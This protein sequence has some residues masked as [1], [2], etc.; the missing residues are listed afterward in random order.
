[1]N[2]FQNLFLGSLLITG[3]IITSSIASAYENN[4]SKV[5]T[6]FH[7]DL[8]SSMKTAKNISLKKRYK[9]IAPQIKKSFHFHLMT[10]VSAGSFWRKA[11]NEQ[12]E[13]LISAFTH[14]TISNYVSRFDRYTGQLFLTKS[15][16]P[17]PQKT[18]LVKTQII[19]SKSKL[20]DITYVTKQIKD[21]WGIIDVL[22]GSGISELA[23]KRSEYQQIL[24]NNG[25]DGLIATLN[26][27]ADQLLSK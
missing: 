13:N 7:K 16:E 12:A 27:K 26:A 4:P 21:K 8:L 10:Q 22:L 24:K 5:V 19:I 1:M 25:I 18:I 6:E 15:Q 14:F 20:I 9:R 3:V 23:V 11:S 2:Y 17:G